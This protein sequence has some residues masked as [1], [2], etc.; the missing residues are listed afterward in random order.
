MRF[1]AGFSRASEAILPLEPSWHCGI[2]A[3]DTMA[4]ASRCTIISWRLDPPHV[5]TLPTPLHA[6]CADAQL[7]ADSDVCRGDERPVWDG[8][9]TAQWHAVREAALRRLLD[10][11]ADVV[12]LQVRLLSVHC[13]WR[14]L[15][16][17]R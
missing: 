13:G 14:A 6:C 4:H 12:C 15:R 7:Q 17:A 2:T 9:T 5:R 16:L 8:A 3:T 1:G 10:A 11:H